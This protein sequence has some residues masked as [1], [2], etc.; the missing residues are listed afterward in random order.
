MNQRALVIGEAL[1]DVVHAADG[2]VTDYPGGSPANVALGLARLDRMAELAAWFGTDE[3][4]RLVRDH[5]E[6][7]GVQ[8]VPGSDHAERTSTAVATLAGDGGATYTFDLTSQVP[9]VVLDD[10]IAV[11]HTGSIAA[12]LPSSADAIAELCEAAREHATISYDPNARPT[13][14]GAADQVRP[15]IEA[16]VAAADVVKVSDEDVAWLYPGQ[17][18]TA[19]VRHWAATGPALVVLTRGGEESFAVTSAGVEVTVPS[20]QVAVVD[21]VGAGDSF[22][23]GLLD[24]LWS[25]GLLGAGHRELL[26]QIDAQTTRDAMAHAARIAAI[27]VS[28]AGA[29]PPT[30]REL[31][32]TE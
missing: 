12:T 2:T 21:T 6:A 26:H 28:R 18:V 4:G 20:P 16:L 5:L 23:A 11:L 7:S 13:I 8:L 14:M 25:A 24:G 22:M 10:S 30:R 15:R 3:R 1:V 31:E 9:E 29:N 19:A 17:D 32:D 27:V